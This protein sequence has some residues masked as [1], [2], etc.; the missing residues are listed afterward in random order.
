MDSIDVRPVTSA[1][2]SKGLFASLKELFE[3]VMRRPA[4]AVSYAFAAG[5]IVGIAAILVVNPVSTPP[6]VVRGTIGQP[7]STIIDQAR[8]EVGQLT[9][10]LKTSD[11]LSESILDVRV[12][13]SGQALIQLESSAGQDPTTIHAPGP[14]HFTIRLDEPGEI[15]VRVSS[16]GQEAATRLVVADLSGPAQAN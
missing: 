6:E 1:V 9:V 12:A 2:P 15:S 4:W 5:L 8:L 16:S 7:P 13:G 14:G 3:P 10:D 11:I